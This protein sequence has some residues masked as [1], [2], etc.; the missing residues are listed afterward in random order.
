MFQWFKASPSFYKDM[1]NRIKS[2]P[3][4]YNSFKQDL[5]I[6]SYSLSTKRNYSEIYTAIKQFI[7]NNF[8]VWFNLALTTETKLFRRGVRALNC[9]D[10]GKFRTS[11]I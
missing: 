1:I 7:G 6:W 2:N 8:K 5:Y 4:D 3:V 10:K 11:P 9:I